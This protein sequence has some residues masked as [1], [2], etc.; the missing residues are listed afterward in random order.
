MIDI[1]K[2]QGLSQKYYRPPVVGPDFFNHDDF[3]T[4]KVVEIAFRP[5]FRTAPSF[6]SC[7][8]LT[9]KALTES[10]RTLNSLHGH[11]THAVHGATY[12][13]NPTYTEM[14]LLYIF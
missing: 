4:L 11:V 5:T 7:V 13:L 2:H 6:P 10:N 1:L 12:R 9:K 3:R 8:L 14:T